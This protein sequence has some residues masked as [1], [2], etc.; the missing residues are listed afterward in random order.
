MM[1]ATAIIFI[2]LLA[3]QINFNLNFNSMTHR[4]ISEINCSRYSYIPKNELDMYHNI[5]TMH[6]TALLIHENIT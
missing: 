1:A 2:A 5:E 4:A 6:S 3:S